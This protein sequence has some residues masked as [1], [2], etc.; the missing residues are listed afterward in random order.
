M[1]EEG[2]D[3]AAI[4]EFHARTVGIEDSGDVGAE[5]EFAMVG[6]CHRLGKS[7][8]FVVAT[9]GADWIYVAPVAFL[10]GVFERVAVAFAGG[11]E[12]EAGIE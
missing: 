8:R 4:V 12:E 3:Y 1:R 7:F 6:H 2:R 10:L 9:S 5:A 11:G